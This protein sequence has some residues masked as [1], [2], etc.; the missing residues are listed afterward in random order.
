MCACASAT[1]SVVLRSGPWAG[2]M[3]IDGRWVLGR[4]LGRCLS[5]LPLCLVFTQWGSD[6]LTPPIS[7][8]RNQAYVAGL[9]WQ[10]RVSGTV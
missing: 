9:S 10:I 3:V 4:E 6:S 8:G 1:G 7:E 2:L 5:G